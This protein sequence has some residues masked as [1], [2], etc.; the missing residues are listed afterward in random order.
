MKSNIDAIA[1]DQYAT[2]AVMRSMDYQLGVADR[3][4]QTWISGQLGG[5]YLPNIAY[6]AENLITAPLIA[7][8]TRPNSGFNISKNPE[9][10]AIIKETFQGKAGF[11]KK[12]QQRV[13]DAARD[14]PEGQFGNTRYTNQQIANAMN[15]EN[16]GNT[17]QAA[18]LS[19]A[20]Q[21]DYQR[22]LRTGDGKSLMATLKRNG[23]DLIPFTGRTTP[24]MKYAMNVD[25]SFREAV[26]LAR[27]EAGD[28]LA[29]AAR[30]AKDTC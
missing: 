12:P 6:Q 24:W 26:F 27:V 11:G 23:G 7:Y 3:A 29:K 19:R 15:T 8:I 17:S 18:E 22:T 13:F 14:N 2:G 20:L 30:I 4:R 25:M 21:V 10:W 9:V 28:D 16:L 5:Q 1:R